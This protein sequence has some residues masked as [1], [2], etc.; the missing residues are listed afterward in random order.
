MCECSFTDITKSA[1]TFSTQS[2]LELSWLLRRN[3]KNFSE[4]L[5][6]LFKGFHFSLKDN[7]LGKKGDCQTSFQSAEWMCFFVCVSE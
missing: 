6:I 1:Y 5:R 4:V 7:V 2:L 3:P